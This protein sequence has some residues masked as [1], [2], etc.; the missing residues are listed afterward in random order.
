MKASPVLSF[1]L[2]ALALVACS[3]FE[4][5]DERPDEPN[6]AVLSDGQPVRVEED[7]EARPS[8]ERLASVEH[9]LYLIDVNLEANV[10]DQI[11]ASE[12][13]MVVLDFIPSEE[14][15]TGFPMDGVRNGFSTFAPD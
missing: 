7:G 6:A 13:D 14:Y 9:W 12:H 10:V 11:V 8:Q 5:E 2:L 1:F 4:T 15:N 3:T